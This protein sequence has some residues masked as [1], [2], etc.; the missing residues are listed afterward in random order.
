MQEL[1]LT[2]LS[3]RWRRL[4]LLLRSFRGPD[5]ASNPGGKAGV[6][7]PL[8][9]LLSWPLP[10]GLRLGVFFPVPFVSGARVAAAAAAFF[11]SRFFAFFLAALLSG[12]PSA[13]SPVPVRL[14]PPPGAAPGG[15]G[16]LS[17]ESTGSAP[18]TVRGLR[19]PKLAMLLLKE[20]MP[21]RT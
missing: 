11:A 16:V 18:G 4:L 12:S 8:L 13:P 2:W 3:P 17:A 14:T 5:G 15:R 20:E 21:S 9:L 7:V 1:I 6:P 10:C 19:A